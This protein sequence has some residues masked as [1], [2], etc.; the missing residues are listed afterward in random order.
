MFSGTV[1]PRKLSTAITLFL[2][3][4]FLLQPILALPPNIQQWRQF[5]PFYVENAGGI[6]KDN[7]ITVTTTSITIT[8]NPTASPTVLAT[9]PKLNS[10]VTPKVT[11]P[12]DLA[13][14]LRFKNSLHTDSNRGDVAVKL[15]NWAKTVNAKNP[16]PNQDAAFGS[17]DEI[18]P[19]TIVNPILTTTEAATLTKKVPRSHRS[20]HSLRLHIWR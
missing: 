10:R 8:S 11:E 15:W 18:E 5:L 7:E 19:T 6:F 13:N 20:K 3:S 12:S 4:A 2:S 14:F 16:E 1:I 9:T 17:A